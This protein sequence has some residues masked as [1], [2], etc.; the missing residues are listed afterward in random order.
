M[1]MLRG[2]DGLGGG[3]GDEEVGV[4]PESGALHAE[5]SEEV[6]EGT[7]SPRKLPRRSHQ[8]GREAS[9]TQIDCV[10]PGQGRQ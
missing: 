6:L 1:K 2:G 10:Q 9:P 7:R 3:E 5:G 4:P 8:R